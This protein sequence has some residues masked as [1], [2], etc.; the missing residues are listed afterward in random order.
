MVPI[1]DPY[2]ANCLARALAVEDSAASFD[3]EALAGLTSLD[4]PEMGVGTI[5]GAEHL[6]SLTRLD[7][8]YGDGSNSIKDLSPLAGLTK[9]TYLDVGG[10]GLEDLS[11][12][13]G[14]TQLTTLALADNRIVDLGPLS[15]LT[16][17]TA[18]DLSTDEWHGDNAVVDISPL[19]GLTQ[20]ARLNLDNDVYY[21]NGSNAVSDLSP[22][23][24]LTN[25]TWLG[26][27]GNSVR[28]LAPLAKLTK[29]NHL[30][31]SD[32]AVSNVVPLA[33]LTSLIDLGLSNYSNGGNAVSDLSPLAGLSVSVEAGSQKPSM[34]VSAGTATT[35]PVK[36]KDGVTPTL[37]E[38]STGLVLSAGN[39]VLAASPGNYS[40]HFEWCSTNCHSEGQSSLS[41]TMT[42]T[43][44]TIPKP[45]PTLVATGRPGFSG[46]AKVGKTLKA[47][48][49]TG[50]SAVTWSQA[51]VRVS[52]QWLVGEVI[53]STKTKYK[54][55]ARDAGLPITFALVAT[56]DGYASGY[57]KA[58]T[59]TVAKLA[60]EAKM[61]VS[62][63]RAATPG[64]A[65]VTIRVKGLQ[66]TGTVKLLVNG[67]IV[68]SAGLAS[69]NKGKIRLQVPGLAKGKAKLKVTYA[70]SVQV[71]GSASKSVRVVVR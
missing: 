8:G 16:K 35:V 38:P 42:V 24:K 55:Q 71:K 25:L 62:K 11:P 61:T 57:A 30:Y 22:L 37:S 52:K 3:A 10:N 36:G 66:P 32:N 59:K 44:K 69:I 5:T 26:L 63:L 2:F 49:P 46:T 68:A 67:K 47:K 17:L 45:K 41:G 56:K 15:R 60:S 19:A 40:L 34:N 27:E 13:A 54:V 6:T 51:G 70:G 23:T 43:A 50:K 33:R 65:T 1:P 39:R 18:L 12:L 21:G 29:L 31:L 58:K 14:L 20:L 28:D 7:L 64:Y 9:L 48:I 4:C 53:R